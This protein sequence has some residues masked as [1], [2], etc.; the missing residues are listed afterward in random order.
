MFNEVM[1]QLVVSE[2]TFSEK[3][4]DRFGNSIVN[5]LYEPVKSDLG[6]LQM[7]WDEAETKR[8]EIEGLLMELRTI[9]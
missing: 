9:L 5:E 7:A 4:N 2:S 3:V 6:K 8:M 1:G